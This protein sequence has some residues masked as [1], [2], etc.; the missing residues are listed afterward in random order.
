MTLKWCQERRGKMEYV[1]FSLRLN[2]NIDESI[3]EKAKQEECSKNKIILKACK[4][5]LQKQTQ[6]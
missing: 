5:F 3:K 1:R 2:K 6:K 4:E